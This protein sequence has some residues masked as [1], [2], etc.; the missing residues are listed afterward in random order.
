MT[1]DCPMLGDKVTRSSVQRSTDDYNLWAG[2]SSPCSLILSRGNMRNRG[3][4]EGK[5]GTSRKLSLLLSPL[6][7]PRAAISVPPHIEGSP[8]C[9][10]GTRISGQNPLPK[11][12]VTSSR[13]LQEVWGGSELP[14]PPYPVPGGPW[15]PPTYV[16]SGLDIQQG[17][18]GSQ[19]LGG[20]TDASSGT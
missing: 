6:P 3:C 8:F 10:L 11:S 4:N 20:A 13:A 9:P 12:Q 5:A 18:K 1:V 15:P 16:K 7:S 17:C 14:D 19:D 2:W